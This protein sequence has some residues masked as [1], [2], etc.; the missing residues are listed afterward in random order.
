MI[1][2]KAAARANGMSKSWI[3]RRTNEVHHIA[4][5][6]AVDQI[7]KLFMP[8]PY[9]FADEKSWMGVVRLAMLLQ[10]SWWWGSLVFE[11]NFHTLDG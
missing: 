4:M 6:H 9:R 8:R 2:S 1:T 7:R 3:V 5:S 11:L 10:P